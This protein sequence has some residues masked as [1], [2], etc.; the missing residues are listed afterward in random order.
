MDHEENND[1]IS[2]EIIYD[3]DKGA[4]LVKKLRARLKKCEQEKK[5]YLDGWQR[6]KADTVNA[7]KQ[8]SETLKTA[9]KRAVSDFVHNLLPALDSFDIALQGDFEDKMDK[10]WLTGIKHV[11]SQLLK[12]L[13]VSGVESYGEVG[14]IFDFRIHEAIAHLSAQ[15]GEKGGKENTVAKVEQRGYKMGDTVIR[16]AKVSVYTE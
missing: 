14:E 2:E 7:T 9:Q 4:E 13:E 3:E 11:H 15:A 16:A 8:Q 1:E 5:E 10:E 12:S 6:L